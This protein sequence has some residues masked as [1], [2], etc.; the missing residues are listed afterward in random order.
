MLKKFWLWWL[1]TRCSECNELSLFGYFRS[2]C[3]AGGIS[4]EWFVC[5]RCEI[6]DDLEIL[7]PK[8]HRMNHLER[9]Y[10]RLLLQRRQWQHLLKPLRAKLHR[11]NDSF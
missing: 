7:G 10:R 5:Y 11:L 3:A 1:S 9:R 2:D 8:L 4:S 6:N